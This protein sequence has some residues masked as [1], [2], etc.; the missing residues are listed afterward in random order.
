MT[1]LRRVATTAALTAGPVLFVVL[2]TA[3]YRNPWEE[4]ERGDPMTSL[5]RLAT[6]TFLAAGSLAVLVLETAPRVRT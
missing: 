5:R 3:G 6:R 1:V 4:M 2:A